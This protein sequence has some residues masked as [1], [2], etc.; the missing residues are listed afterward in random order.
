MGAGAA[1]IGFTLLA[2]G[3]LA[4]VATPLLRRPLL[5]LLAFARCAA[6]YH[7]VSHP[8]TQNISAFYWLLWVVAICAL[9]RGTNILVCKTPPYHE[10]MRS[11]GA[12]GEQHSQGAAVSCGQRVTAGVWPL[13]TLPRAQVR[14]KLHCSLI[15][16]PRAHSVMVEAIRRLSEQPSHASSL[17]HADVLCM[18]TTHGVAHAAVMVV[19]LYTRCDYGQQQIPPPC[20]LSVGCHCSQTAA[21]GM[22]HRV[23]ACRGLR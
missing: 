15:H 9:G 20:T 12:R 5:L 16:L 21:R 23:A 14:C 11:T 22:S 7:T 6:A 10:P 4:V 13:G 3:P 19:T 1:I 17:T 8:T 2:C 18:Y